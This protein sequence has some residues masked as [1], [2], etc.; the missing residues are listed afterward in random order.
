LV[1]NSTRITNLNSNLV[2]NALRITNL[3]SNLI[4]NSTRITNLNSNLVANAL[5]ITNL[6]SN[7]IANST[8]ITNLNSNLVANALRIT[9]LES[10][11]VANASRITNLNSNLVANALRITNLESNLVANALRITNLE[12]NLVANASRISNL[13]TSNELVWSSLDLK[14]NLT[15][16]VFPS[17]VTISGNL[18]VSGTTTT[19]NTENLT[20]KDPI[21]ALS[22]A[23]GAVDSGVLIN[24]PAA[25]DGNVF[26]GFDHSLNEYQLGYTDNNALDQVITVKDNTNFVA[27]VHGNVHAN[28]FIG[29]GSL[30]TGVV[31]G[32]GGGG[33]LQEITDA[34][35]TTSNTVQFTNTDTSFVASGDMVGKN[36][37][38]TNPGIT[39]SM[40]GNVLTIDAA[41]KTYGT[42]PLIVMDDNIDHLIY[43]NLNDGA[44]II[45]PVTSSGGNYAISNTLSN[46]EYQIYSDVATIADGN[47]GL[48]TLTKLSNN[49]YVNALPFQD[50]PTSSG[51]G[52]GGGYTSGDLTVSGNLTVTGGI[53]VSNLD[54]TASV[55]GNVITLDGANRTFG[56]SPML[57]MNSNLEHLVYTNVPH[58]SEIKLLMN[59]ASEFSLLTN[60]SNIEWY[61]WTSDT[62]INTGSRALMTLSNL[63][64]DIYADLKISYLPPSYFTATGGTV[65]TS[66][67]YKIHTFTS[68]GDFT[69]TSGGNVEYLIVA[70]GGGAGSGTAGGGGAGG[71]RSSVSGEISGR[72]STSESALQLSDGIYTVV[73][74]S[75]GTGGI[76]TGTAPTNGS[77]SIFYTISTVGGGAGGD[78]NSSLTPRLDGQSGGSGGGGWNYNGDSGS[79]GTG[80]ANQGFDGGTANTNGGGGGGGAGAAGGGRN[81]GNGI[82]STISGTPIYYGGGGGGGGAGGY[83]EAA[84]SG[85]LGGGGGGGAYTGGNGNANTGGGGGGSW[86]YSSSSVGGNG[87]SGIVII[88]YAI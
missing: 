33:T 9:N 55:S 30:L 17:N 57:E 43:S 24:R 39:A 59:A 82:Q 14:A 16:P 48:L 77:S 12:S 86:F 56:V 64:G 11:L 19:L 8:R 49:V 31:T 84:G 20:V 75:G 18:T 40:T 62:T 46:V 27:N 51:G 68:S 15:D 85:G 44:Q 65:T 87:G 42:G 67:G 53:K 4:A 80:T 5:R 78:G 25:G 71:Y 2:A 88:R 73:V 13:E 60:I 70:G 50:L 10:N 28:Y 3:E 36:I 74:G 61:T 38:L 45:M 54:V 32:S 58:G 23:A 41:D 22:N 26:M 69:V 72:L 6:E 63:Y 52:G 37:Q 35:N 21:I 81:G 34:G 79:S 1:A 29:D 83:G 7:L 66:D 47:H 76:G